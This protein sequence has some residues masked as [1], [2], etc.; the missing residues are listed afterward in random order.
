MKTKKNSREKNSFVGISFW[1]CE[2]LRFDQFL[3]VLADFLLLLVPTFRFHFFN[4]FSTLLLQFNK[5]HNCHRIIIFFNHYYSSYSFLGRTRE[6]LF[7][8]SDDDDEKMERFAFDS[9]SLCSNHG[10]FLRWAQR[11][12]CSITWQHQFQIGLENAILLL[13]FLLSFLVYT[14]VPV[15]STFFQLPNLFHCLGIRFTCD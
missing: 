10:G 12:Q 3:C 14:F 13:F 2:C 7:W 1:V 15:I 8:Q 6:S 4:F 5:I 11:N 9:K